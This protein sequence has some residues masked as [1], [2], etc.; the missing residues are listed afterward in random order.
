MGEWYFCRSWWKH[1]TQNI[2]DR[3]NL[4]ELQVDYISAKFNA[5]NTKKHRNKHQSGKSNFNYMFFF[6]VFNKNWRIGL[7]NQNLGSDIRN[8]STDDLAC[9][10]L[11][12]VS[13]TVNLKSNI[14][15]HL[16]SYKVTIIHKNILFWKNSVELTF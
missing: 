9:L 2:T 11:G 8:I 4:G 6:S 1:S 15:K 3:I 12:F 13:F 5:E 7:G 16:K 14:I 10:W